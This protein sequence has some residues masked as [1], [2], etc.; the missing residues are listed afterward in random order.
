MRFSVSED[1]IN[2]ISVND[3]EGLLSAADDSGTITVV[4]LEGK[5]VSRSLRK[6]SNICSAVA[7]R[8]GRPQSMVSCGLD[9]QVMLWDLKKTRPQFLV[10]LQQ[11]SKDEEEE[12]DVGK[13]LDG[14]K[15]F[16]PPLAHSLSVANCGNIFACGS[17]DGRIRV[18]RVTGPQFELEVGFKGHCKGVSQVQ[19][20]NFLPASCCLLTGGN[21]GNVLLWDISCA[22]AKDNP[23]TLKYGH[24]RKIR[25]SPLSK[26]GDKAKADSESTVDTS[27]MS[28]KLCVEHGE[29]VNWITGAEIKGSKLILVADQ[30]SS[31]SVYP[32]VS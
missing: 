1:E 6:H 20:L 3:N 10:N 21:D 17:E 26:K 5:K 8:P 12:E 16:N 13:Q 28:P 4:D 25:R 14:G 23:N 2:C 18:F 32:I 29:K 11:L 22:I 7:F 9:M 31:V 27:H 15:L 19:F 24:R 30:S